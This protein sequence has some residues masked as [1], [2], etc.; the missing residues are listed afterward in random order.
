VWVSLGV[1][2][3]GA[4]ESLGHL[5]HLALIPELARCDDLERRNAVVCPLGP[6]L[7]SAVR[8]P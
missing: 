7:F 3:A 6:S 8:Q 1:G 2:A 5:Q 4:L